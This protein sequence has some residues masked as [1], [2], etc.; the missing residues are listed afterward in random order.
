MTKFLL[1]EKQVAKRTNLS[2]SKIQQD[3]FKGLGLPY[4][5]IGR[6]VRYL[7]EDINNFI[8]DNRVVPTRN[9]DANAQ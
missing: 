4:V 1:T 6:S 9:G 8:S 5:K 2:L 7:E 3:R